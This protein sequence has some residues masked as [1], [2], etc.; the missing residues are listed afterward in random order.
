[1]NAEIHWQ[2]DADDR[3]ALAGRTDWSQLTGI[4]QLWGELD[5][6]YGEAPAL[7]APHGRHPEQLTYRELHLRIEQAAAAFVALGLA[8]GERV[9]L[10][11]ENGP[12]WLVADQ[13][14]MRAGAAD[15]VRGSAA[16]SDEL[17]YILEDSGSVALVVESAA[18]LGKL[19][20][21]HGALAALRFVVVLEGEAPAVAPWPCLDWAALLER[22]AAAPQAPPSPPDPGRLATLLYTSGTTGA[23]KGVPLS[24]ANLLHQ[25]RTLGVA[26]NPS[27][28]DRVVSVLPI[29]HAYERTAEYLLLACGCHQT[30]TTLKQLRPDLQR[31]RPSYMISVPRLWEALLSGFE[32]ALAAMPARRQ[33]LL[34]AAL[35]V[36]RLHC[37]SRR[38]ALDLTLTQEAPLARL[39]GAALAAITWP[40]QRLAAALFWPKVRQQ[41]A[42]GALRTAISGGGA[43]APH[44]DGFFEVIGIELLVGYGLTETSPV[45]T[46]RRPW[47]NRRGSSGRPLPGTSIRIV[48]P[49][50]RAPLG[51]G[52]RGLVLAR[53]PQVMAGYFHRPEATASAIDA[54]GWFDTGDLGLLIPDGSLLLTGRAKDTIVLSSGENIEPGPLEEALAASPLVEQVLV[55]GQDERLLGALVVPRAD[56]LAAFRSQLSDASQEALLRALKGEFNRLLAARPGSRPDERLG[57]VALVEPF[58]LENGLLT[59]TLKQRRDRITARDQ[60]AIEALYGR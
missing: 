60:A 20:F 48:N 53:G 28:G 1:M 8:P 18:L 52:E 35:A 31:V 59:Q 15:A 21:D 25:I 42:G 11:A 24:H 27:P 55:V 5:R 16:P 56:P 40:V 46:C 51:W 58:S 2:A 49:E 23:P 3:R 6:L 10:F 45:L 50:S 57:G 37:T 43:L 19:G 13:G 38:Q 14:L 17:L 30:Y 22:G 33:K 41:L 44:V 47:A 54:Q 7:D 12:R 26:V 4:E 36:G 32:D 29:W 34:K 39:Q 9:A